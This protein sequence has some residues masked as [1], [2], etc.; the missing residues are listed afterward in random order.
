MC[1]R[2]HYDYDFTRMRGSVIITGKKIELKQIQQD[3]T[4]TL[5]ST[6]GSWELYANEKQINK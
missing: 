2:A 5:R 3:R 4:T 1:G 6:T